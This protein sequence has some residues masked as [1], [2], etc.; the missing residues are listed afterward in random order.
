MIV[1][2]LCTPVLEARE[3]QLRFVQPNKRKFLAYNVGLTSVFTLVTAVV[4]RQI[5]SP[6]DAVRDLLIGSGAGAS[7]YEAKRIA[8][9]GRVT[10]GWLIAN[11][12]STIIEN[13]A[14]GE[15]PLGQIG[16]TVGPLRFRFATPLSRKAV[17]R[18]E[19]DWS[20]A[21]TVFLGVARRDANHVRLRNGL[22]AINRDSGWPTNDVAGGLFGG[23]TSGVFPGV[24]PGQGPVTWAHETIHAIQCQQLDSVEP[25]VYTFDGGALERSEPHRLFAIRHVRLG[26]TH[27]ANAPTF[28]RPYVERWG[29]VEA[30]GLAQYTP[31]HP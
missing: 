25:P 29:E 27:L 23:R 30:Y 11:A 16:Y 5:H 13:T 2:L 8:G 21:E 26:F 9:G 18:I 10:E 22:I 31:V 20:L 1:G 3:R 24:A 15:H 28:K 7:F 14:S 17:A 19:A 4:Q 12:A 6:R